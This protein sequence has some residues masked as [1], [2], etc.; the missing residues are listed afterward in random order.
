MTDRMLFRSAET[1]VGIDPEAAYQA[2]AVSPVEFL[3]HAAHRA[4]HRLMGRS[5]RIVRQRITDSSRARRIAIW[6]AF[7]GEDAN[8]PLRWPSG[9]PLRIGAVEYR[10]R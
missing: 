6:H 9:P 7:M 3:S 8:L 2:V 1:G 4:S 10:S 5:E